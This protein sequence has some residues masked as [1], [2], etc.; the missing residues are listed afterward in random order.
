MTSL[1]VII[2]EPCSVF[3]LIYQDRCFEETWCDLWILNGHAKFELCLYEIKYTSCVRQW[4]CI[5]A[6]VRGRRCEVSKTRKGVAG[7]GKETDPH[8]SLGATC[9]EHRGQVLHISPA[10]SLKD[11]H[12]INVLCKLVISWG[13][14]SLQKPIF[15]QL[16]LWFLQRYC[17]DRM[18]TWE[19]RPFRRFRHCQTEWE[20]QCNDEATSLHLLKCISLDVF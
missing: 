10:H 18:W 11:L 15:H 14:L 2:M 17:T 13:T 7:A 20:S 9:S 16:C 8:W 6:C 4:H 1:N 12:S 5:T 3:F 19:F